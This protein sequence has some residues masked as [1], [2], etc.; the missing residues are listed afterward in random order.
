MKRVIL[1]LILLIF[2]TTCVVAEDDFKLCDCGQG[3]HLYVSCTGCEPC[4]APEL[5]TIGIAAIAVI[6]AVAGGIY[7]KKR[8]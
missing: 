1:C 3:C 2:S 7:W 6:A 5:S 8:K 4:D